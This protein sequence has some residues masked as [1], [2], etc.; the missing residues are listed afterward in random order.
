MSQGPGEGAVNL[1]WLSPCA[2]SLVALARAPTAAAWDVVR[3]DP[4][5]V[6]L[7]LRHALPPDAPSGVSFFPSLLRDPAPLEAALDL[8]GRPG[9]GFVDWEQPAFRPVYDACLA[10]ARLACVIAERTERCA[11]DNAW[12]A[13]LLAPLGWL[14]HCAAL[15]RD[16]AP[17]AHG[18]QPAG[19]PAFDPAAL[20]R[21]LNQCWR[22]PRWLR[23]VTGHLGLP[24]EVAQGLGADPQLFRVVQLAVGLAR[25]QGVCLGLTTGAGVRELLVEL[26][27]S[28]GEADEI[29]QAL[30]E[31]P[32]G[33]LRWESPANVPL[34][35]DLLRLA[36]ENRRLRDGPTLEG[37][38][39]E[40]DALQRAVQGQRA[41]EAERLRALKL[42][43]L[44]ELAAGAGHEINNP[45]AVIS[46]QAQYL[47]AREA[48]AA[49]RRSLQTVVNQANRIHHTLTELMQFARPPA[50]KPQPVDAGVLLRQAAEGLRDL[51]DQRQVRLMVHEPAAPLTLH[52]DPGQAQVALR[53]LLRNAVEAAPPEGWAAVR[54]R[55]DGD[56]V[57]LLVEDSGPGPSPADREH[58]FDPFYC[59]R[60]A[61]RGRGLGLPTAWRLAREQGGD[62][63][64]DDRAEGPTRFT[65]RLPRGH[66][67]APTP[68]DPQPDPPPAPEPALA[69]PPSADGAGSPGEHVPGRNG[70][71]GCHLPPPAAS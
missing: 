50:P 37:L 18:V 8:L 66:A 42:S 51:A 6:L 35:P 49:R 45:L 4:G 9:P 54:V 27:L 1:T 59:G 34:L 69:L 43:A 52:A 47:L 21:R 12:V 70:S 36:A 16:G 46:G 40:I 39:E 17:Q 25:A 68:P 24:V 71:N 56:A 44:V 67:P 11:P 64:Y 26:N 53:C 29:R 7:L 31:S 22:L 3:F 63:S 60:K 30:A 13:G 20:A 23:A 65:L 32:P 2:A 28:P 19:A 10:Y 15:G 62:V 38:Q 5:C 48:D 55:A 14:A 33:P 57:E 58:F 41:G 61:G